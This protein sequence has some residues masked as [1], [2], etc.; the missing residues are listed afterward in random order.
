[1]T[2]KTSL[3]HSSSNPDKLD[4]PASGLEHVRAVYR[5]GNQSDHACSRRSS[6]AW[7]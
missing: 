5:E 1:V 4:I 6:A 3:Q 2:K 7:P